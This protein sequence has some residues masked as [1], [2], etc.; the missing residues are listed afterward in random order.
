[1]KQPEAMS[2]NDKRWASKANKQFRLLDEDKM[3]FESEVE[4][5]LETA[6]STGNLTLAMICL[7]ASF[8]KKNGGAL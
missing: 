8:E 3:Q 6:F 5:E 2:A 1:M 7:M 4:T